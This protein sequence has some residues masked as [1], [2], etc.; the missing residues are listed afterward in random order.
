MR[1]I[2][3]DLVG[4]EVRR[5]D[6]GRPRDQPH[7]VDEA[8][9]H[10]RRIGPVGGRRR[11][12]PPCVQVAVAPSLASMTLTV[13]TVTSGRS[14]SQAGVGLLDQS[15]RGGRGRRP[16]VMPTGRP[17]RDRT[18]AP[19]QCPRGPAPARGGATG[20]ETHTSTAEHGSH[21][22]Q[23]KPDMGP[24]APPERRTRLPRAVCLRRP[25]GGWGGAGALAGRRRPDARAG[26]R[27]G[28]RPHRAPAAQPGRSIGGR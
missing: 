11:H 12:V 23:A 6:P 25:R 16:R 1:A 10:G 24:C 18:R 17:S 22:E 26:A 2:A 4:R 3:S 15:G 27:H 13:V 21:G 9:R 14:A 8:H 7:V 5:D 20:A 28:A 19:A